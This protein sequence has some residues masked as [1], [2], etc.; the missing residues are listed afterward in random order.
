MVVELCSTWA[1]TERVCVCLNA[2]EKFNGVLKRTIMWLVG[3]RVL[4]CY[5]A[6]VGYLALGSYGLNIA[7][8]ERLSLTTLR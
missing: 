4:C 3:K 7:C 5:P 1:G 8:A 2:S 6:D